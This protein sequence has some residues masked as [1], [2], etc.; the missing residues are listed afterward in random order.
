MSSE[1]LTINQPTEQLETELTP[2]QAPAE[3]EADAVVD[4]SEDSDQES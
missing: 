4:E 3:V 1:D 2:N